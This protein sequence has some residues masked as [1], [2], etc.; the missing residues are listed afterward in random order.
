MFAPA[1]RPSMVR[2]RIIVSNK[3]W[4]YQMKCLKHL[5]VMLICF[6][7][8]KDLCL[9]HYKLSTAKVEVEMPETLA[10]NANLFPLGTRVC[11]TISFQRQRSRFSTR[12]AELLSLMVRFVRIVHKVSFPLEPIVHHFV[13]Q[14]ALGSVAHYVLFQSTLLFLTFLPH[15]LMTSTLGV[16]PHAPVQTVES[17]ND[18][19]L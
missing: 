2:F 5:L 11:H 10:I 12:H 3:V 7:S 18:V 4:P 8:T 13:E 15:F 14:S 16:N 6:C 1:A 9:S 19:F 17:L